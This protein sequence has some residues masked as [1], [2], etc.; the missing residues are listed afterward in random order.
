MQDDS[1]DRPDD[2]DEEERR[3]RELESS[4]AASWR[5]KYKE[6]AYERMEGTAAGAAG[7]SPARMGGYYTSKGM[8]HSASVGDNFSPPVPAASDP[9]MESSAV[10]APLPTY[11]F[12]NCQETVFA[13]VE[14][15]VTVGTS[16][17]PMVE[18]DEPLYVPDLPEYT[19]VVHVV[20]DGFRLRDGESWRNELSVT[21]ELPYP[22]IVLHLT[23]LAQDKPFL[24]RLLRANYSVGGQAIGFAAR[25]VSVLKDEA[26]AEWLLPPKQPRP[27]TINVPSAE[28]APDLTI[29][30]Q[31]G[32]DPW[33]LLWTFESP[34]PEVQTPDKALQCNIGDK[35]S[36]FARQLVDQVN[37]LEGKPGIYRD[38]R[39]IGRGIASNVPDEVWEALRQAAA[40]RPGEPPDVLILSEEPHVPWELAVMPKPLLDDSAPPFLAA[41]ANLGRWVIRRSYEDED[42]DRSQD[43][44]PIP[45]PRELAVSGMAVVSGVYDDPDF[46][47]LEQ[48][49]QETERLA[50]LYGAKKVN[51]DFEQVR[52]CLDGNP[53]AEVLHFAVHG[54]YD[55]RGLQNGLILTDR[56]VL[57]PTYVKGTDLPRA[58][59]VFLNAC[60]VGTGDEILGDYSGL[61]EAFLYAGASGVIAPLWSVKDETA[62]QIALDFY[63]EIEAG[64]SPASFI[65]A[66]R[67]KFKDSPETVSATYLAYQ[68]FG[69][70]RLKLVGL[71]SQEGGINE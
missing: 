31:R 7:S 9:W 17:E 69:H 11:A 47:T 59:F 39:G 2:E 44:P 57:R 71:R 23:P 8:A 67:A 4:Q 21:R 6:A 54:K 60:Q 40:R 49:L 46:S 18:N 38:L 48:A 5:Q 22:T 29:T 26:V 34:H 62:K 10:G 51:A 27:G 14:L 43:R 37:A 36:E 61:A 50:S 12:L 24:S 28:A 66:E 42:A 58:P 63:R 30:I 25:P 56:M 3:R 68:F 41:Q 32:D 13:G 65:R 16:P 15:E 20:A 64:G 1:W 55:P 70:P 35:P 19:L 52:R 45:P 33:D 53:A